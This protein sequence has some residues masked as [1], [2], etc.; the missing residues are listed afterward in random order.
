MKKFSI[1]SRKLRYGGITATL[2]ALTIAAV[3]IINVVFSGLASR[4]GWYPDMTPDKLYTISDECMDLLRNGDEQFDTESAIGMVDKIRAEHKAYNEANGLSEGDEGYK[5][6][7]ISINII[8]CD[9][10]DNVRDNAT[11]RYVHDSAEEIAIE[12][13]EYFDIKYVDIERNPSAVT[14]YKVSAASYV[15]ATDVIIEF[16]TEFR[17]CSINSFYRTDEGE[18]TPWAYDGERR[19]AGAILAVT[20]AESPVA[21]ISAHYGGT[22]NTAL[23]STLEDAGYKVQYLE[24][25]KEEIPEDCRLFVFYNPSRDINVKDG[26]SDIDEAAKLDAFLD[27]TNSMMVF[28]SPDGPECPNLEEYLSEWGVE[29]VRDDEHNPHIIEDK[30]NS[31]NDASS[32]SHYK[33]IGQYAKSGLGASFTSELRNVKLPKNVVFPRAM[34]IRYSSDYQITHF[35]DDGGA[36]DSVSNI[37]GVVVEEGE[38]YE[39]GEYDSSTVS[40][41]IFDMFITSEN[42]VAYANGKAVAKAT[43]EIR[44]KLMTVTCEYRETQDANYVDSTSEHSYVVACGSTDFTSDSLLYS[45]SYG[46][47]DLLLSVCRFIGREPVPVGIGLKPFADTTID[48]ITAA[49]AIRFTVI[50]TVIPAVAAI[51]A[52]AVVLVRRKNK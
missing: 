35:S 38:S 14:K 11:Q 50:L 37:P 30:S 29:F 36:S 12:F 49:A 25:D 31:L 16:G 3:I 39:Y 18:S 10:R 2:T 13:P 9:Y 27:G 4:F 19:L 5:D 33:I 24:L 8:F 7:N 40:R 43:D 6:E 52:G 22:E 44:M 21:C 32:S 47:G 23:V 45:S 48:N 15:Y 17:L 51:A 1:N 28:M 20:R 41:K 34:P 46:N 26:V 42:A